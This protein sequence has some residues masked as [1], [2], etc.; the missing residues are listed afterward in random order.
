ME[1]IWL[2]RSLLVLA[3][4]VLVYWTTLAA[5]VGQATSDE[6]WRWTVSHSL[7]HLFL[8][9]TSAIAARSLLRGDPHSSMIV[10]VVAGALIVL[11]LEGIARAAIGGS[12]DDSSL[13]AHTDVL[14][15]AV[16]LAMGIWAASF[17]IRAERRPGG[18]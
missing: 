3:G 9:T 10:A 13:T 2:G 17:A 6:T 5:G 11:A 15:R 14:T 16:T 7:P 18:S 1:A 4:F 8:V 12:F